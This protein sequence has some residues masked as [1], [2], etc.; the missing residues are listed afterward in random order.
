M[1]SL[2]RQ[3]AKIARRL[4]LRIVLVVPFTVLV[5]A[6][7]GITGLLS[8][9]NGQRAIG[10]L[11][12]QLNNEITDRIEET[13][14]TYL[15]APHKIDRLNVEAIRLGLLDIE[16][17]EA[18]G[19]QFWQQ[20]QAF[21]RVDRIYFG[22]ERGGFVLAGRESEDD[23][24]IRI[25]PGLGDEKFFIY[26]AD[27]FGRPVGRIEQLAGFDPRE[28]PWYESARNARGATW[29]EI[30]PI[31]TDGTLAIAA[32]E[33]VYDRA[34]DLVG[35]VAADLDLPQI[36]RFLE[37]LEIA[38]SG[39]VF[40]VEDSGSLVA[41]SDPNSQLVKAANGT[42]QPQRIRAI[43]SE[44]PLM[45]AST[46]YLSDRFG[47]LA[48]VGSSTLSRLTWDGNRYFLSVTPISD[49]RGIDW[50]VVVVIPEAELMG[51]IQQNTREAIAICVVAFVVAGVLDVL[52]SR[53]VVRPIQRLS[54]ASQAISR[55]AGRK[56][57]RKELNRQIHEG[58]IQELVLLAR[59]FN[60]M[61]AQLRESFSAWEE[62]N[63]ELEVRVQ[64]RTA[65]LEN[66]QAEL[67][68]L[69]TAMPEFIFIKDA[70]GRYLKVASTDPKMLY[71]TDELVNKTEYDVFEPSQAK[72]FVRC[73]RE[74][75]KT[76]QTVTIEYK[77]PK[78]GQEEWFSASISPILEGP[79]ANAI[80]KVIWVARNITDRKQAEE[81]LQEQKHYLRLILDNIPQQVFWKDANLFFKGCNTNW[82]KAAHLESPDAVRGKT[83]YD[84]LPLE[85]AEE[86]RKQDRKIIETKEPQLHIQAIKQKPGA[87]GEKIW[88]DINKIPI[89]DEQG[90]SLGII[91]VLDDITERKI[92]EKALKDEQEK[93]DKL[94]LNI[95]PAPIAEKL[96]NTQNLEIKNSNFEGRSEAAI[97]EQFDCAT[98]LFADIVG[99][100][101]LSAK[102]PA[103][104]LVNLLNQIFS[105]FDRLAQEYNLEKIKTIGDAYMVAG[106]LPVPRNDSAEAIANMALDIQEAIEEVNSYIGR[107][108]SIRIGINTGPVVAGVIGLKK[109]SYDLWGDTVNVA[110][111]MESSGEPGRIQVTEKTYNFLKNRYILEERGHI[112]VKGKGEMKTYW[113]ID[114]K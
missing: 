89:Y 49:D 39:L 99:F 47:D 34:G 62:T 52:A 75:L 96:K 44:V 92:S 87:N 104:E 101:P 93:S 85:V 72:E 48:S 5:F 8:V 17:K 111:R 26:G 14:T 86:F 4:P 55:S 112:F 102:M 83:D 23:F 114:R 32:S 53:W 10:K 78:K 35:V 27:D 113:L 20:L 50:S 58:G 60:Q 107:N 64:E 67:R 15:D 106:G 110:S 63:E 57:F 21:P 61:A 69:F 76:Q 54:S 68:A 91:G 9:R 88:L 94:L 18:L 80:P 46:A 81:K 25:A 59:S 38:K 6:A 16:D 77:L 70:N 11:A 71:K 82:A 103:T 45:R 79:T 36:D 2:T 33:P 56:G 30:Y 37:N 109:F 28:R 98:I 3:V 43:D 41:A 73:I 42:G 95:L 40:I 24:Q 97:A 65:S 13:L 29:S 51:D 31:F 100:T 105:K 7:V 84:L 66:A 74:A 22:D 90:N 108:L 1:I 19:Q 12:T